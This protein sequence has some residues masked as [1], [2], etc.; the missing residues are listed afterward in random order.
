MH[1]SSIISAIVAAAG[2]TM[3][4]AQEAA[5]FGIVTTTVPSGLLSPNESIAIKY[6]STLAANQPIFID[7]IMQGG[8][9]NGFAL[10]TLLISRNIYG[11]DQKL[12]LQNATAP[13]L[14]HPGTTLPMSCGRRLHST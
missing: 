14:P 1:L 3:V 9:S 12:L 13:D 7:F 11:A 10:P 8:R 2:A 4:S 6:N 5:R